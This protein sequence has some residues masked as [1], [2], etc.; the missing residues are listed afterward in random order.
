M[1]NTG[2]LRV[3]QKSAELEHLGSID[4]TA[5]DAFPSVLQ[6]TRVFPVHPTW[7]DPNHNGLLVSSQTGTTYIR[8]SADGVQVV[9]DRSNPFILDEPT[10]TAGN[11]KSDAY[12]DLVVQ[13][14]PS[15]AL[16]VELGRGKVVQKY[17]AGVALDMAAISGTVF[18]AARK[19][20]SLWYGYVQVKNSR[21]E[22]VVRYARTFQFCVILLKHTSD[23]PAN[24][25]K[26]ANGRNKLVSGFQIS[27]ICVDNW[28]G[29]KS[30]SQ[31]FVIAHWGPEHRITVYDF[32][33]AHESGLSAEA[34]RL[35]RISL[36]AQV[37][38]MVWTDFGQ[39]RKHGHLLAG[40]IDGTVVVQRFSEE[41]VLDGSARTLGLGSLPIRL[42]RDGDRVLACGSSAVVLYWEGNRLQQSSIA[43]KVRRSAYAVTCAQF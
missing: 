18:L 41:Y 5:G 16:L 24:K 14:T 7:N 31:Q 2:S 39:G 28:R 35:L 29:R 10:L 1:N 34:A 32:T 20:G 19:D 30:A 6:T 12:D 38:S 25:L 22:L 40:C 23:I 37:C 11:L 42:T 33:K 8:L 36:P 17:E 43:L 15:A 21:P 4:A 26:D 9:N 3:V 27:A 13:I